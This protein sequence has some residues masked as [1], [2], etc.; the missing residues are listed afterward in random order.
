MSQSKKHRTWSASRKLQIV[1]ESLSSDAK[2]AELCRREGL[3]P[4]QLYT[5]RK[6]LQA[7]AEQVF[8]RKKTGRNGADPKVE[9]LTAENARMKSVIA[10]VIA[11]NLDLKKTLSD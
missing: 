1:L 3:S 6:A 9:K 8:A 4:T 5:W 11:E 7:S 10:E 2:A